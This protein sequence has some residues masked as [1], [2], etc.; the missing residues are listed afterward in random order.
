MR[1]K[2]LLTGF[3]LMFCFA[4]VQASW[5]AQHSGS[6]TLF[7]IVFPR[8]QVDTGFACGANSLVLKTTDGGTNWEILSIGQPSG[9]FNDM[10]FPINIGR[11]FIAWQ[12]PTHNR[13]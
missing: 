7:S 5:I 13:W 9:T 8:G 1:N 12:Y 3:G 6:N 11:G 4:V 2:I 10:I